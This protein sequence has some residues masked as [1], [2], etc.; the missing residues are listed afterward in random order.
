MTALRL[1]ALVLAPV[2]LAA[3]G[4]DGPPAAAR[5]AA[6]AGPVIS[7][8]SLMVPGLP[9]VTGLP[10]VAAP[11]ALAVK[12]N[13]WWGENGREWALYVNGRKAGSGA[14]RP[15]SPNQQQATV[16]LQLDQPGR[17]EIK[18]ALCNDH[19][20]SESEPAVLEVSAS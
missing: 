9:Q 7:D 14:L 20:C 10:A 19:G 15:A 16:D 12:W 4:E 13:M 18:V 8:G 6:A 17:Y 1:P 11:G 3:C 5:A 2:L